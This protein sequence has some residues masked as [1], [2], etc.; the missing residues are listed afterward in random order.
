MVLLLHQYDDAREMY[1][2]YLQHLNVHAV[3]V[4]SADAALQLAAQ[5]DVVITGIC[6]KGNM[7]GIQLI[8]QLRQ[9]ETT[10]DTPVII[11]TASVLPAH[12]REA[13]RAGCNSFLLLP[14]SPQRL[15]NEIRL[16]APHATVGARVAMTS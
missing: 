3:G 4:T 1:L 5:A 7:N 9:D 10:R 16:V 2:E 13:E 12:R 14:C 15:L 6:L 8:E 11:L